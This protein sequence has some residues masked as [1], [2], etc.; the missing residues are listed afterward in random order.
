MNDIE[1]ILADAEWARWRLLPAMARRNWITTIFYL[2]RC[3]AARLKIDLRDVV[4]SWL[5]SGAT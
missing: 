4:R 5:P 3:E 1:A 2:A